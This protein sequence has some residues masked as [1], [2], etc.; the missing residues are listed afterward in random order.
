MELKSITGA[1]TYRDKKGTPEWYIIKSRANNQWELPKSDV[2]GG[3][4]SV[5]AI[6]RYM[7]ETLGIK[8]SVLEEAARAKLTVTQNGASAEQNLYF[9]IMK[10]G[11]SAP[12]ELPIKLAIE[13]E[14]EWVN[15][16]TAKR[17]LSLVR[18]QKALTQANDYL[19]QWQKAKNKKQRKS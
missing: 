4:S 7:K 8:A 3:E 14:G 11:K 19:K 17:K 16:S 10:Q 1:V 18:E 9:Y 2:R 12:D 15:Y 6:L 5:S 13:I